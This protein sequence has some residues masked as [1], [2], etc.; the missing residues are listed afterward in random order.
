METLCKVTRF[1]E[2]LPV[3]LVLEES[4]GSRR[5]ASVGAVPCLPV[6]SLRKSVDEAGL[7]EIP[8]GLA[9]P[10]APNVPLVLDEIRQLRNANCALVTTAGDLPYDLDPKDLRAVIGICDKPYDHVLSALLQRTH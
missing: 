5:V 8:Y 3:V 10:S 6:E 7:P 2:A 4:P 9:L 1:Y